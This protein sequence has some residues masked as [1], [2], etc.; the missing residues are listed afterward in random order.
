MV[1]GKCNVVSIGN[2]NLHQKYSILKSPLKDKSYSFAIKIVRLI[3]EIQRNK[4]EYVISKQIL[5]SGT[6]IGA[7]IREAEFGR[8]KAD[9]SYKLNVALK[10]AYETGYWLSLL[11]DTDYLEEDD[12][13]PLKMLCR[14]LIAMLVTSVKTSGK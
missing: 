11:Y 9:F 7:L 1:S 2:A 5:R 4:K 8:S 12:F 14:E 10:E 3:Q 6:A 13:I